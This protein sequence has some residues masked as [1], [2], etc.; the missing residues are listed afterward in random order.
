MASKLFS[1]VLNGKKPESSFQGLSEAELKAL[2]NSAS[3]IISRANDIPK[4]ERAEYLRGLIQAELDKVAPKQ[5]QAEWKQKDTSELTLEDVNKA[6]KQAQWY[7][8]TYG[9]KAQAKWRDIK[10]KTSKDDPLYTKAINFL[11]KADDYYTKALEDEAKWQS[12]KDEHFSEPKPKKKEVDVDE[13]QTIISSFENNK[14][15]SKTAK[16]LIEQL[17]N[18]VK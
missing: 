15:L 2:K 1:E 12:I 6:L 3:S 18:A 10:A 14:K 5:A 8:H 11:D 13:L 17:K 4:R 9:P 16:D 7:K